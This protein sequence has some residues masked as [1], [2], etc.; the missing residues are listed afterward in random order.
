MV[1]KSLTV[2][3]GN[4]LLF[5]LFVIVKRRELAGEAGLASR[6]KLPAEPADGHRLADRLRKSSFKIQLIS[7]L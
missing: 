6:W 3:W 7:D 1:N 5:S 4:I 2:L